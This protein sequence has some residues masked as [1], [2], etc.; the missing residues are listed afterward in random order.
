MLLALSGKAQYFRNHVYNRKAAYLEIMGN[1]IFYSLNYEYLFRDNGIKM[2]L[3]GGPCYFINMFSFNKPTVMTGNIEFVAFD[4]KKNHHLE[5]GAGLN[6]RYQYYKRTETG[7]TASIV[8]NDTIIS[9]Y[10]R[11]YKYSTTGPA[12]VLRIG[13][14]YQHHDGGIVFRAGWTP[15]FHFMNR[16]KIKMNDQII[17]SVPIPLRSRLGYFGVSIGYSFY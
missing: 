13:Y 10:T 3:R 7:Y 15:M 14:R 12:A 11:T 5:L 17:S 6:Y 9:S 4:G 16:E 1:G 2:G 8:N